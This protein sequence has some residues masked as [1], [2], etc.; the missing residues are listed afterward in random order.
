[1]EEIGRERTLDMYLGNAK[2][3]D[4][5]KTKSASQLP[6]PVLSLIKGTLARTDINTGMPYLDELTH[7]LIVVSAA[8]LKF[9]S[10]EVTLAA[11]IHDYFKPV[12]DFRRDSNKNRWN[13]Y[14]YITDFELYL[15]LLNAFDDSINL[16]KVARISQWHHSKSNCNEICQIERSDLLSALEISTPF[17]LPRSKTGEKFTIAQHLKVSG[18]YRIFILALLKEKFVEML[19]KEYSK[20]FQEILGVSRIRYEYRPLNGA[21]SIEKVGSMI[22]KNG[23]EIEI[24]DGTMI[25]PLPSKFHRNVFYFEY[26]EDPKVVLDVDTNTK[27][28]RGVKI[29]FGAALFTVYLTGSQDVYLLYADAGFRPLPLRDVIDSALSGLKQSL[30]TKKQQRAFKQ[31]NLD[32]ITKSLTGEF[33][34]DETCVFCGEPGER[35]TKNEKIGSILRA[36]FTDTWLLLRHKAS[37]CPVC[38]LGFEIEELFRTSG[39]NM[40]LPQEAMLSSYRLVCEVPIIKGTEFVKSISSKIWLELLSEMYYALHD[41]KELSEITKT[42]EWAVG[43]YLNPTILMYPYE[44]EIIP[45]VMAVALRYQKKKFVLQSGIHS[46]VVFPGSEKDLLSDEFSIIRGVYNLDPGSGIYLLQK[47]KT[48]YSP[49]FGVPKVEIRKGGGSRA[50]KRKR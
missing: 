6:E 25:I 17:S 32:K 12:F 45:Q 46:S 5:S 22:K 4:N 34:S 3:V 10:P 39:L 48:V 43:F 50:R 38:K 8:S 21:G 24:K 31:I 11:L 36:K 15:Q 27:D 18:K 40:Y 19:S 47:L 37:V 42:K 29:P 13:W 33:N 14:H 20:R 49:V 1:M 28:I 9:N 16:S 35:I 2:R 41:T 30:S 7:H 26:Y 44:V 23:W